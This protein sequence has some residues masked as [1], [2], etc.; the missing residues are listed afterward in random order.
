MVPVPPRVPPALTVTA[1]GPVADPAVLLASS[2]P[3]LT[4]VPPA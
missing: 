4:V 3:P 1:P 2:V